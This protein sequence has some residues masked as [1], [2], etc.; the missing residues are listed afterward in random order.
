MAADKTSPATSNKGQF[1]GMADYYHHS[2]YGRKTASGQMLQKHLLTAAHR[3]LPFGTLVHVKNHSNGRSCVVVIND[4]GPFTKSKVIDLS[5]QAATELNII[6]AGTCKVGCTVIDKAQAA[7]LLSKNEAKNPGKSEAK[8]LLAAKTAPKLPAQTLASAKKT[9]VNG[10]LKTADGIYQEPTKGSN[11]P[12][13]A[14]GEGQVDT[15]DKAEG[16]EPTEQN[17]INYTKVQ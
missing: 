1:T 11:P 2:L 16:D 9:T 12:A 13:A 17:R 8:L 3:T 10:T 6:S 7:K 5:H 4:R 14:M 15:I